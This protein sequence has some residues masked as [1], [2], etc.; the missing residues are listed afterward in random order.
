M[1]FF[2]EA[3]WVLRT[4]TKAIYGKNYFHQTEDW[5][6]TAILPE[7][8]VERSG[9]MAGQKYLRPPI[10]AEPVQ[11]EESANRTDK[12]YKNRKGEKL[13]TE[14]ADRRS[15]SGG[16][17][18]LCVRGIFFCFLLWVLTFNMAFF[19]SA[20]NIL[21]TLVVAIGAGLAVWGVIN[22]LEGY[23][24]DNPGAKSQ[25]IKQL[26]AGGGVVLIGTQLIPLLGG[27]FG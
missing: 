1:D 18:Y 17:F 16:F 10:R 13:H 27:L 26:M 15:I 12:I 25:G 23:G 3:V 2:T 5:S 19:T 9:H 20:I 14:M 6:K 8:Q 22:L 7:N 24:N 11:T 4:L 21:Q